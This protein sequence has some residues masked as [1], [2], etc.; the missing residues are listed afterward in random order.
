MKQLTDLER[1]RRALGELMYRNRQ[2][3]DADMYKFD[4]ALKHIYELAVE[5]SEGE[6]GMIENV[7]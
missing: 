1:A 5:V 4:L 3:H 6:A 7:R 2:K